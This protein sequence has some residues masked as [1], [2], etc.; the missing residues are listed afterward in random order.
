MMREKYQTPMR[1]WNEEVTKDSSSGV[2]LTTKEREREK[3]EG[4]HCGEMKGL[5]LSVISEYV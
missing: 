3:G 2:P 1:A 5:R 4:V